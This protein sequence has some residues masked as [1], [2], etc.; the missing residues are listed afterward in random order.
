MAHQ[1]VFTSSQKHPPDTLGSVPALYQ[2]SY[3]QSFE[4]RAHLNAYTAQKLNST[5]ESE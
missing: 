3:Q 2:E 5:D 4:N 1:I